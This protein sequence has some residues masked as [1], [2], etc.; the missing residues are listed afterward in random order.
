MTLGAAGSK[1]GD[2]SSGIGGHGEEGDEEVRDCVIV[3]GGIAGLAAAADLEKA[4]CNFVLLE[5]GAVSSSV[6]EEAGVVILVAIAARLRCCW[7][8][9]SVCLGAWGL[10]VGGPST[11]MCRYSACTSRKGLYSNDTFADSH[12]GRRM[13]VCRDRLTNCPVSCVPLLYYFTVGVDSIL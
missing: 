11:W 4:G 2:E 7:C 8:V 6:A 10:L 12:M 9:Y 1:P 5:A 13:H 3:G